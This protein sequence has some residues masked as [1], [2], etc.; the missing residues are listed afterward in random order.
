MKAYTDK[1][2]GVYRQ[3]K[4]PYLPIFFLAHLASFTASIIPGK[5]WEPT[6]TPYGLRQVTGSLT[7]D[8]SGAKEA[9]N[10]QPKKSF[11]E[12]MEEL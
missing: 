6:L 12:G 10:W 1:F 4:L 2:E 9:L 8:I 5:P 7:L 11:E 3:R